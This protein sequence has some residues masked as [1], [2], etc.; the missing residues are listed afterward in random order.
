GA[1]V[2]NATNAAV[3]VKNI[4]LTGASGSGLGAITLSGSGSS[5]SAVGNQTLDNA[6]ISIGS[7]GPFAPRLINNNTAGAALLTLRSSLTINRTGS[8]AQLTPSSTP[9][10][11]GIANAGTIT[12]GLSGGT[13]LLGATSPSFTNR[14]TIAASNS[15]NVTILATSF[16][17]SGTLQGSAAR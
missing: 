13:L 1:M 12:A 6:T 7:G 16:T 4:T 9:N 15:D 5:V 11:G 8:L 3:S 17:N 14:G 10:G 2:L